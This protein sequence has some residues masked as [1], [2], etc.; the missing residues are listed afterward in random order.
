MLHVGCDPVTPK[1]Y[2]MEELDRMTISEIN[3]YRRLF[4]HDKSEEIAQSLIQYRKDKNFFEDVDWV[5]SK[6]D[7]VKTKYNTDCKLAVELVKA[8]LLKS[9]LTELERS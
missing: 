9:C 1:E 5:I 4:P 2:T 3:E 7:E 8:A 6:C